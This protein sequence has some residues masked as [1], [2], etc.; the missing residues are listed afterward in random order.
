[1]KIEMCEQMA[2]SWLLNCKNC[3]IAQTN[4]SISPS[5]DIE[6]F[7]PEIIAYIDYFVNVLKSGVS[8]GAISTEDIE[9]TPEEY[10]EYIKKAHIKHYS[11]E[12]GKI[13]IVAY[14]ESSSAYS[15]VLSN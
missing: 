13:L 12:G 5:V 3:Q 14:P 1:M 9:L 15:L 6:K 4:W 11:G 8:S 10:N 2:Q 7:K